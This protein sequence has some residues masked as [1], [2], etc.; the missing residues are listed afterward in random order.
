M[1]VTGITIGG[2]PVSVGDRVV[3]PN[4]GICKVKG[5]ETKQIA[6]AAY[7]MLMLTRE[8]DNATVMVPESK[9]GSIGLRKVATADAIVVLFQFLSHSSTDPELDW[10]IRHRE[11]FDLMSAGGLLDTAQVLKGLHALA[12]IRPLPQKERE[13]YDSARHQLVG[14]IAAALNLPPAV[15]E[16]NIDYALT[17]PPGS[18]RTAPKDA[19]L[20]MKALRRS[21]VGKRST[22]LGDLGD[23]EGEGE[24]IGLEGEDEEKEEEEKEEGAV[25][26]GEEEEEG[27]P[28]KAA[29]KPA[30]KPKA[31]KKPKAE[32]KVVP[33]PAAAPVKAVVA[34]VASPPP[35]KAEEPA[36]PPKVVAAPPP[37][38]P[39]KVVEPPPP[40]KGVAAPAPKAPE[41]VKAPPAK[42][43]PEKA[44]TKAAPE[45]AKPAAKAKPAPK[46]KA[47]SKPAPAKK[48]KTAPKA[49]PAAKKGGRS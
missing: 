18:G 16:N 22:T 49:K 7:T 19:P 47:A 24:D 48:I 8:E 21:A 30:P 5:I 10:K 9:V 43:A 45:K 38:P 17:P 36:P 20:D 28:P 11:N 39:T 13:M 26:G 33:A 23:V 27:A 42:A 37:P 40:A 1:E 35:P 41:P 15:A 25:E 6:G 12:Q 34:P 14:E 44:T 46:P 4:G 32:D 2:A 31:P 3:Y 29:A